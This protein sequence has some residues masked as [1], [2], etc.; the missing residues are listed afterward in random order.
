MRAVSRA[1]GGALMPTDLVALSIEQLRALAD[2][3]RIGRTPAVCPRG[4]WGWWCED[5]PEDGAMGAA[6]LA[7]RDSN[8]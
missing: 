4:A 7:G 5:Y 1:D 6:K 8:L 3:L 2:E